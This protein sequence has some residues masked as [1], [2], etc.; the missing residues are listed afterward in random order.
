MKSWWV[1]AF[2]FLVGC[3]SAAD[4]YAALGDGVPTG[5]T[6]AITYDAEVGSQK[7]EK[8]PD[9]TI[10]SV[11]GRMLKLSELLQEKPVLVYF[12]TTWCP[13]CQHDLGVMREL[14]P[15][16]Q[17]DITIVA[18]NMDLDEDEAIIRDYLLEKPNPGINF[19]AGNEQV[20]RDYNIIYTSTKVPVGGDGIVLWR[21]SG[22]MTRDLFVTLFEG[23]KNS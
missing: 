3:S 6:G 17:D 13:A 5:E 16:Y 19:A 22:E 21:G 9:F 4:P 8:A 15:Q 7:G 12:W 14:Y 1:F 2:V 23:L 18:I 20:L 10:V 11:D